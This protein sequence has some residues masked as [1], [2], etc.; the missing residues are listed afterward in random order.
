M[1]SMLN[2]FLTTLTV[3]KNYSSHTIKSYQGDLKDFIEFI[4][5]QQKSL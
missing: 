2:E 4:T 1:R 5:N 3:E